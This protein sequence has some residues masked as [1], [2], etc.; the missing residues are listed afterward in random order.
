MKDS[1]SYKANWKIAKFSDHDGRIAE[2]LRSGKSVEEVSKQFAIVPNIESIPGNIGLN[3]GLAELIEILCGIGGTTYSHDNAYIGVGDSSTVESASH[4]GLQA[5][6]N[7][8]YAAM[9]E[10]YPQR[11]NQTAVWRATFGSSAANF[12][13][14]EYTIVNAATDAGKNLNRKVASKGTK[15]SGETWTLELQITFS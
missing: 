10:T 13:W 1:V 7:K 12:A 6:T 9:D 14:Q 3:E 11:S 4:T 5:S 8:A 15:E 2:A